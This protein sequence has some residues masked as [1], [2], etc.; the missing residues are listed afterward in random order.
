MAKIIKIDGTYISHFSNA[1]KYDGT[2]TVF[3][4]SDCIVSI[5]EINGCVFSNSKDDFS[6]KFIHFQNSIEYT[7]KNFQF[8]KIKGE[9]KII[10]IINRKRDYSDIYTFES[11]E[12]I[13]K[14]IND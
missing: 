12:N 1:Q 9:D 14:L 8:D 10:T 6:S 3:I 7:K 13:I 2:E 5:Y 11:L 4:N